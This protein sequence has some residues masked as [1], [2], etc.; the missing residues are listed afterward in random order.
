[1]LVLFARGHT[2]NIAS[3]VSSKELTDLGDLCKFLL[4]LN[5]ALK[6]ANVI[7]DGQWFDLYLIERRG[8][9][10]HFWVFSEFTREMTK[11]KPLLINMSYAARRSFDPHQV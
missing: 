5:K 3:G 1:M 8:L 10:A 11:Q 9:R 4:W 6:T 2:F 7:V